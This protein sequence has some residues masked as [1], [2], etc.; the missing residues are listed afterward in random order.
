MAEFSFA[1]LI[2]F[3]AGFGECAH[4][5]LLVALLGVGITIISASL[6]L[7]QFESGAGLLLAQLAGVHDGLLRAMVSAGV[8]LGLAPP[9]SSG[10]CNC[11]GP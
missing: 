3:V 6:G 2:P 7:Y 11:S 9:C 5:T 1:A 10:R 8:A 4:A